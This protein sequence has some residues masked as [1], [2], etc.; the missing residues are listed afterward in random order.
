MRAVILRDREVAF[1]SNYPLPEPLPCEALIKV[2]LAGI[3]NTDL[4]LAKGYMHFSGVLGHEFVGT[5]TGV[6]SNAKDNDLIG[7]RVVGEINIPC[8][9]CETCK[10][11]NM[12]MHCKSR[13][14]LGISG[15]DGAF[16]EYLTL[17]ISNL[18]V[19]PDEVSDEDAVF[20]E[21]VAACIEVLEQVHIPPSEPVAIVGD[22]KLGLIMAEVMAENG[23]RTILV[24]KHDSRFVIVEERGVE[25]YL[26]GQ[27][28][29]KLDFV[30][31]CSGSPSGLDEALTIVRPRGT[32]VL[33]STFKGNSELDIS[34]VVVDEINIVGS[35][36]GPFEPALRMIAEKRIDTPELIE[37]IFP[38]EEAKDALEFAKGRLK[39][40]LRI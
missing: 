23:H 13:K 9:A 5:V 16:A 33:K 25:T 26:P 8:N 34:K 1:T 28:K 11:V 39:V 2:T 31:E 35:R 40:L 36:C 37:K 22:G 29:E 6:N 17:P 14:V 24:G 12:R 38:I 27:L 10:N 20:S 21:P 32:I 19:V 30:V 15:K 7:R 18:H 3:C 4:E